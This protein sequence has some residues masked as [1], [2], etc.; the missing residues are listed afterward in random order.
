MLT[1]VPVSDSVRLG[2]LAVLSVGRCPC[3]A[4]CFGSSTIHVLP[5]GH[6]VSCGWDGPVH[7]PTPNFVLARGWLR[8]PPRD[9]IPSA[10]PNLLSLSFRPL[11][12]AWLAAWL[13]RAGG[14]EAPS[15]RFGQGVSCLRAPVLFWSPSLLV[16]S[17]HS[18]APSRPVALL[19]APL[20]QNRV[21]SACAL[22]LCPCLCARAPSSSAEARG[23]TRRLLCHGWRLC[24]LLCIY[25]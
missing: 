1:P 20:C 6:E 17:R 9:L 24:V 18:C 11:S 25:C 16:L 21:L 5:S 10:I 23:P 13:Q 2:S 19:I 8:D 3:V 12:L 7:S 4:G 14:G 22:L 15:A